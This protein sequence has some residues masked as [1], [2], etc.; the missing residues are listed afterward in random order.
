[1]DCAEKIRLP[2]QRRKPGRIVRI[3][4]RRGVENNCGG[5]LFSRVDRHKPNATPR[6]D[7]ASTRLVDATGWGTDIWDSSVSDGKV[8]LIGSALTSN[9]SM[10][11]SFTTH[12]VAGPSGNIFVVSD[13]AGERTRS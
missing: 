9:N 6:Y 7:K 11:G 12:V 4:L 10:D 1:M 3:A 2:C 5:R 8:K 13:R